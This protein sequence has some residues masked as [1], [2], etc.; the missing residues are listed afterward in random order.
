MHKPIKPLKTYRS[1]VL[2][3]YQVQTSLKSMSDK[4]LSLC[5]GFPLGDNIEIFALMIMAMQ[6]T[7]SIASLGVV[8]GLEICGEF[9]NTDGSVLVRVHDTEPG[10]VAIA[11]QTEVGAGGGQD[12]VPGLKFY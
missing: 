1:L 9:I 3:R 6:V 11:G 7:F 12:V 4:I 8:D 5:T 10:V 2:Q